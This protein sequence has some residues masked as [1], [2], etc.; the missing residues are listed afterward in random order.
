VQSHF[1]QSSSQI[2]DDMM[3]TEARQEGR[4]AQD[5]S[6]NTMT[7]CM[8]NIKFPYDTQLT[9]RSL[10]FAAGEDGDLKM[11]PPGPA[12]EHLALASSSTSGGSCS[13]SDP[14]GGSYIHTAKIVRGIPVVASILRPLV[15]ASS[16]SSLASTPDLDS[17]DDYPEIRASAYGK[18]TKGGRLI[19]TVAPNGDRSHNSSSIYP[20]IGRSEVSDAQTPSGDLVRNLNLDFNVV[21]VQAIMETIQRMALDGSSLAVLAQQW[22]KVA[23]LVV[24]EKS[25]GIPQR[26][27]SVGD[28]DRARHA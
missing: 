22:A 2:S 16:S 17:S 15:K 3:S 27:P 24:T 7:P 26:E 18:P 20:T 21:W 1:S 8:F 10:T 19:C 13:G 5:L 11:L 6:R 9:F 25:V 12:P 28:N 4:S 14:C 23:N